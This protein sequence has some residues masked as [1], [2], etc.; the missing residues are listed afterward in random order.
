MAEFIRPKRKRFKVTKSRRGKA[1]RR[2]NKRCSVHLGGCGELI[3]FNNSGNTG[4]HIVPSALFEAIAPNPDEFNTEWNVQPMHSECNRN[5]KDRLAGRPLSELEAAITVGTVTPDDWP[6]FEC[7][8]HYLRIAE[9][10]MYVC[11]K[12]PLN[13]RKHLL[14]PNVVKDFGDEDRQD[15]ILVIGYITDTKVGYSNMSKERI[16]YLLPSFSPKRV[17]GFN[18]MEAQRVG[19]SVPDHIYVD[20]KGHVTPIL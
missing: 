6:R 9:G 12:K 10:G 11:T 4:D 14:Y 18:I 5:K 8:C 13:P 7:K 15:A 19:L 1:W 16:G 17:V 3:E 2:D 20:K